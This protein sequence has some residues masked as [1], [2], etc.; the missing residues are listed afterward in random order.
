[1]E[2]L[3]K[4]GLC[5]SGGPFEDVSH[6]DAKSSE[7]LLVSICAE[8]GLVQQNP[9][10]SAEEL[11][12]YYSHNYRKDYK[13]A[14]TPKPQHVYRAGKTALSRI[15][16]LRT[17]GIE[18]GTLLD[19][20]AGGG[21]LVYLAGK[22]GFLSEGVEPSVGYSEYATREY[23]CLVKTGELEDID[24]KF[25]VI[26]MFHVMEHLPAPIR[27]FEKLY[28]L[29][30]PSG[31]LLVEVP[32]IE[33]NDASPDNIFFK[34]HIFYFTADT[35]TACASRFFDVIKVDTTNNLKVLFQAKA[36]AT[37]LVL[38]A[39]A[40]VTRLKKRLDEKGW[41]EYLIKGKG[42]VK[43]FGK[44][45]RSLEESRSSSLPPRQILDGLFADHASQKAANSRS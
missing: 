2:A 1:M 30:N 31:R 28:N 24:R 35:L 3:M 10:P 20:G 23:G 22:A 15:E 17:A 25:D 16:F 11:K 40:S 38:P 34:A 8:C 45:S 37:A 9:I 5:G 41:W 13:N 42:V 44:L 33:T 36:N 18:G 27:A 7:P 39:P 14:Y 19:I 29:L 26:T 21:E 4:C 6:K 12:V 32:W 43:P